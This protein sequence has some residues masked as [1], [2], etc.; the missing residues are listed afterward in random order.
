MQPVTRSCPDLAAPGAVMSVHPQT[1]RPMK[2]CSAQ[3][4][5]KADPGCV[6]QGAQMVHAVCRGSAKYA[7][8]LLYPC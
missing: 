3:T 4:T 5:N 6:C 1:R 8:L 2:F 7:T